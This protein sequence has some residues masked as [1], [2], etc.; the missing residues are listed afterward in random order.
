MLSHILLGQSQL[1]HGGLVFK[2]RAAGF[3]GQAVSLTVQSGDAL[4]VS[5]A[6]AGGN[7]FQAP[8]TGAGDIV[9][10]VADDTTEEELLDALD[11]TPAFRVLASVELAPGADG[12]GAVG[13]LAKTPFAAPA[14]G[15]QQALAASTGINNWESR[16]LRTE[17]APV[18]DIWT[19]EATPD[20]AHVDGGADYWEGTVL[21]GIAFQHASRYQV[22]NAT[23]DAYRRALW[24]ALKQFDHP[25]LNDLTED[26]FG[27]TNTMK[28]QSAGE[29]DDQGALN[30]VARIKIKWQEPAFD[31]DDSV[32][33]AS[34]NIGLWREPQEGDVATV[35]DGE[36]FDQR[37]VVTREGTTTEFEE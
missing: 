26:T 24:L 8:G 25:D 3:R 4:A 19:A 36:E 37:L 9:A 1:T 5:V 14:D 10:T 34:M 15:L 7:A 16:V 23:L 22:Q 27:Y 21:V 30:V 35:G 11:D 32:P 20:R 12:A 6:F 29:A 33:L 18:G 2:A 17:G 31:E 13:A 28:D